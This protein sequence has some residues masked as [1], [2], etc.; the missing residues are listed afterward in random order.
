VL[1]YIVYQI[2][3]LV[4]FQKWIIFVACFYHFP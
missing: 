2:F 4:F 1:L 3:I